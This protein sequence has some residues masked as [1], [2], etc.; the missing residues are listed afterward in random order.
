M[1]RPYFPTWLKDER[2]EFA[3]ECIFTVALSAVL[4]RYLLS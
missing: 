2:T 4:V 3:L 1:L